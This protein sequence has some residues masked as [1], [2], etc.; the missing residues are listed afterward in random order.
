[1][2]KIV[3]GLLRSQHNVKIK[4]AF[5]EKL[6]TSHNEPSANYTLKELINDIEL[7][8]SIGIKPDLNGIK[9]DSYES[10]VSHYDIIKSILNYFLLRE[11]TQQQI[12]EINIQQLI[13]HLIN[14]IKMTF[15]WNLNREL[16]Y[17]AIRQNYLILITWLRLLNESYLSNLNNFELC[18]NFVNV[19]S[20]LNTNLIQT[21]KNSSIVFLYF[22]QNDSHFC[23]EYLSFTKSFL[24]LTDKYNSTVSDS[25]NLEQLKKYDKIIQ[26]LEKSVLDTNVLLIRN[27]IAKKIQLTSL[28]TIKSE[29]YSL[30][31]IQIMDL[32]SLVLLVLV[33][34]DSK[35]FICILC[36]KN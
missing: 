9:Q 18:S 24:L 19:L 26:Y 34:L 16:N 30:K 31:Y 25:S 13:T 20:T 4:R 27:V 14:L 28:E 3:I 1:M 21:D 6:I 22:I 36:L 10:F 2:E 7:L 8:W 11:E 35:T 12:I 5:I 15:L 23:K 17:Y 33:F 29:V 32:M